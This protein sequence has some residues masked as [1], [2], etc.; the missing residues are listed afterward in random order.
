MPLQNQFFVGLQ[1]YSVLNRDLENQNGDMRSLQD[2]VVLSYGVSD[3][4]SVDLKGGAGYIK[5]RSPG[6]ERIDYST[7]L[8]GGYGFRIKLYGSRKT[9]MVF[10]FQHISVHPHNI[11]INGVKH[12]SVLDDWQFSLLASYDFS[13]FTPYAGTKWSRMDYIHWVDSVRERVK[14]DE[15]KSAGL[16]IGS[17]IPLGE[18]IWLNL[19]GQLFDTEAFAASL[20][21]YF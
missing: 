9:K 10:G 16:V 2:F 19:E 17:D 7:Y 18:K 8:G 14:S 12:K 15:T 21:F 20:N 13:I 6:T 3:W 11:H 1:T 4:F 5:Q